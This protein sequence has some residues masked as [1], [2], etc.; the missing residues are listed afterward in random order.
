MTR[1]PISIELRLQIFTSAG[2]N[3]AVDVLEY[4]LKI[5]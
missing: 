4:Q 3:I 2:E 1:L 5:Y